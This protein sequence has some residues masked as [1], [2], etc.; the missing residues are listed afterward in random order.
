MQLAGHLIMNGAENVTVNHSEDVDVSCNFGGVSVA[1]EY[2]RAANYKS[3]EDYFDKFQRAK[4]QYQEVLFICNSSNK[5]QINA[6]INEENV[7]VRGNQVTE[8]VEEIRADKGGAEPESK[9][10]TC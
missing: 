4:K 5:K 6:S 3:N 9:E 10:S 1:F 8:W 2:E 7:V